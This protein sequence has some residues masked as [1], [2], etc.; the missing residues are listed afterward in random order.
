MAN[1]LD[2]INFE[3]NDPSSMIKHIES[4]PDMCRDAWEVSKKF[5]L[6]AYY[7]KAKKF[8]LLGMGGSGIAAD[9]ISDMLPSTNVIVQV[10]HDYDVPGWV[11]EETI[12]VANSY[13]GDTEETL[14]ALIEANNLRAKLIVITTGGKIQI[15]ANKYKVPCLIFDYKCPPRASFPYLFVLL[16]SVFVKLGQIDL[17][18]STFL[19]SIEYLESELQK[20]KA[21]TGTSVNP[22]KSLALKFYEKIPVIY[23]SGYLKSVARRFKSQL[24]EN[25]KNLAFYEILPELNHNAIEGHLPHKNNVIVAMLESNYDFA[26]NIKRQ[27]ITSEILRNNKIQCERIKFVPCESQLAELLTSVLFGDF[28]SYYLAI[29]N[30]V[31]PITNNSVTHLKSMLEK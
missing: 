9:I 30:K 1:N 10:V 22:A 15:L 3:K 25:S 24:N 27:N 7:I 4:F 6:P 13:S 14:S 20:F 16:L 17:T 31:D 12:V 2:K 23:G 26:R 19:K 11:D 29:L 5:A 8:V 28:V 18:D 21:A